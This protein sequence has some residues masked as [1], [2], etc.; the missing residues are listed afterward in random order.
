MKHILNERQF[1][2]KKTFPLQD[3]TTDPESDI[4]SSQIRPLIKVPNGT[5]RDL[6]K[7]PQ[8]DN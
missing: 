8:G 5:A 4:D 1:R 3:A 6:N 7:G 2:I